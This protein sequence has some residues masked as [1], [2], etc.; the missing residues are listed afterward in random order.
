MSPNPEAMA[1]A[2][3]ALQTYLSNPT[4]VDAARM[5]AAALANAGQWELAAT[6]RGQLIE[7]GNASSADF[8]MYGYCLV[9]AG[10]LD[11]ARALAA[12]LPELFRE[13]D[14][15]QRAMMGPLADQI[16]G[17]AVP[18]A[19]ATPWDGAEVILDLLMPN[20]PFG[21]LLL[22]LDQPEADGVPRPSRLEDDA[23]AAFVA[24]R[25]AAVVS[26]RVV[27]P[28]AGEA[29]AVHRQA[30]ER[31]RGKRMLIVYRE[32]YWP[33]GQSQRHPAGDYLAESA[34]GIGLEVRHIRSDDACA[35]WSRGPAR[36]AGDLAEIEH[37]IIDWRP[38][39]VVYDNF[40]DGENHA[41]ARLIGNLQAEI[42]F[43]LVGLYADVWAGS[44]I[45]ALQ[46]GAGRLDVAW[47][48]D[49]TLPDEALEVIPNGLGTMPP[50]PETPFAA[51]QRRN[52]RTIGLGFIGSCGQSNYARGI[53]IMAARRR[54]MPLH[55]EMGFP[56]NTRYDGVEGFADF[57]ASCRT[58]LCVCGRNITQTALPGRV[59]EGIYA[60]SALLTDDC[61]DLLQVLVPF[62]H[63][64]PFRT[65][66]ELE[67]Y[68]GFLERNPD[69]RQAIADAALAFTRERYAPVRA[70]RQVLDRAFGEDQADGAR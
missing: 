37:A 58:S 19:F 25:Q 63:Y 16:Y 28:L 17:T 38:D 22:G 31:Y 4:D 30:V 9:E 13:L 61:A 33:S 12:R 64:I 29:Q 2:T 47:F 48:M 35:G 55:A 57:L 45:A 53:W 10:A 14:G 27:P 34:R 50:F 67:F 39:V 23:V 8:L 20:E 56:V 24:D 54:G 26:G 5:A 51:A 70:W 49:T 65:L 11:Q 40:G 46:G 68:A 60:G 7:R 42:G 66:D 59:W 69:T 52:Q 41:F 62:A 32:F 44:R 1:R 6:V 18:R 43:K 3:A 15:E 36:M 21:R